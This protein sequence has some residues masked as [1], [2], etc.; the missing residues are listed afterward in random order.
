MQVIQNDV[1]PGFLLSVATHCCKNHFRRLVDTV[2]RNHSEEKN[3]IIWSCLVQYNLT[4]LCL[5]CRKEKE[6]RQ[7]KIKSK[8]IMWY[9]IKGVT[10]TNDKNFKII[11]FTHMIFI[12]KFVFTHYNNNRNFFIGFDLT[13]VGPR[14]TEVLQRKLP[15]FHRG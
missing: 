3:I 1:Y 12:L 15:N 6:K 8:K 13:F 11:Y 10:V 9:I 5:G 14:L 2:L 4:K 7:L